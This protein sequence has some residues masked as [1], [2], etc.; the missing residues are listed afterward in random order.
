MLLA[1]L[2]DTHIVDPDHPAE[3][4]ADNNAR[5]AV[6]VERL[7]A[8]TVQPD[9]V[10]LTGDMTDNGSPNEMRIL[11]ELLAPLRAPIL[12][13]PGNHDERATFRAAFDMPWATTDGHLSWV[14][15]VGD[16]HIIGLDTLMPGS[17]A[18]LFD[19]ERQRWLTEALDASGGRPTVIAMHHPPFLSGMP[20][21]DTMKLS[22]M[23]TFA[24]IVSRH[25][26][27]TR[28]LCGHL[29]RPIVTMVGGVTTTVGPSTIHHIE[30]DLDPEAE[31]AIIDDPVGYHLHNRAE[32]GWVSHLRYIDTGRGPVVPSWS[33]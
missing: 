32:D 13:L 30:L 10:L 4:L 8:E 18:G 27:V 24:E 11:L 5:L 23:E 14:S 22:G 12:A 21:M 31:A 20:W 15:N 3:M 7:N 9:V 33:S 29:H 28:I 17:H 1:Q 19:P 16:L 6:A 2:T 26:N 25:S